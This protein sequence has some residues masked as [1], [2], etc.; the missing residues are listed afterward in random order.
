MR[1]KR[2]PHLCARLAKAVDPAA[3]GANLPK[4]PHGAGGSA[5][6]HASALG[7]EKACRKNGG[8]IGAAGRESGL[9]RQAWEGAAG[10]NRG[11][12]RMVSASFA[13]SSQ[14]KAIGWALTFGRQYAGG[15]E[16]R[17]P[18]LGPCSSTS[19]TVHMAGSPRRPAVRGKQQTASASAHTL[20]NPATTP[21]VLPF[22]QPLPPLRCARASRTNPSP[23][24]TPPNTNPAP[25]RVIIQRGPTPTNFLFA[26]GFKHLAL[27]SLTHC[28]C[29]GRG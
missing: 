19:S 16:D 17:M 26:F 10:K 5:A 4:L 20:A 21:P 22:L 23:H 7:Q 18:A 14:H 9:G 1:C 28:A 29:K 3:S 11:S 8:G 27:H 13:M 2:L 15:D 12:D 24:P 25:A 6:P